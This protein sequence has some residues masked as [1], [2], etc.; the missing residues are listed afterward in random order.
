ML[1]YS[2][3]MLKYYLIVYPKKALAYGANDFCLYQP[4]KENKFRISKSRYDSIDSY[5]SPTSACYNDIKLTMDQE[6]YDQ[7]TAEGLKLL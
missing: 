3:N 1:Q 2:T 7:L 4:L 5:L 6:I